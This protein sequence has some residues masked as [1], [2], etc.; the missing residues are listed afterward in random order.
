ML[1]RPEQRDPSRPGS[2]LTDD[3][4]VERAK[5]A[6]NGDKFARLWAGDISGYSSASEAELALCSMLAFWT[7]GDAAQIDRL[8]TRSQLMRDKWN[9]ADYRARTIQKAVEGCREVYG[10]G[11]A[12]FPAPAP[13][14]A[15]IEAQIDNIVRR[16]T[17]DGPLGAAQQQALL[18]EIRDLYA[19]IAGADPT[20][21]AILEEAIID[22][23]KAAGIKVGIVRKALQDAAK[24]L[25]DAAKAAQDRQHAEQSFNDANGNFS[26]LRAAQA[27]EKGGRFIFAHDTD[28]GAGRLL[29][30]REGVWRPLIDLEIRVQKL[31]GESTSRHKVQEVVD[32]L[33]RDVPRRPWDHF[34][35][36]RLLV[37]CRNGM[38]DPRTLQLRPHSPDDWSTVQ[39][40]VEWDPE[41]DTSEV[42]KYLRTT[43]Q[44][45]DDP[46]D[47]SLVEPVLMWIGLLCTLYVG[48]KKLLIL[49]GGTDTGKTQFIVLIRALLGDENV[50]EEG[51]QALTTDKFAKGRLEGNLM[52][53]EDDLTDATIRD[54]GII[55]SLTGGVTTIRIER[56]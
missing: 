36:D 13:D 56:K 55:K 31:L 19:P 43:F 5:S 20:S 25:Q 44:N 51:L 14:L 8:F 16:H 53:W 37:N 40:P 4:I 34:N 30:Y 23:L 33:E 42:E 52:C 2:P 17:K 15:D 38:L 28:S 6:K 47:D 18:A 32:A 29:E 21:A 39:I 45:P 22:K 1:I 12:A 49:V 48:S 50:V 9:R 7:G 35:P 41:A 46:E 54:P 27:I 11:A 24:A 3:E 10:G 26:P